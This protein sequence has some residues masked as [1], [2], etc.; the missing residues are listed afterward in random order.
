MQVQFLKRWKGL[1]PGVTS[2]IPDGAAE[3][4]IRRKIAE[5]VK[6]GKRLRR[7]KPFIHDAPDPE[8]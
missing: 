2:E 1:R 8:E 5:P 6:K 7:S 3:Q 4:L